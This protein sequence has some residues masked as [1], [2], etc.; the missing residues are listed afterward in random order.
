MHKIEIGTYAVEIPAHWNE[1]TRE[2]IQLVIELSNRKLPLKLFNAVMLQHFLKIKRNQFVKL[3]PEAV[4]AMVNCISFLHMPSQ[5]T[6]N[7]FPKLYGLHGAHDGLLNFTFEQFFEHTENAF[8][9]Y[10]ETGNKY[11]LKYLFACL[12]TPNKQFEA[13]KV[14][15]TIRR[16]FWISDNNLAA[17]LIFYTGCRNFL[18]HKFPEV[19]KKA[20][21][22]EKPKPTDGLEFIRLI[23]M[24][25]DN[26]MTKN[27]QTRITP[28]Y[29]ALEALNRI[30]TPKP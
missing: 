30:M 12:Y 4:A 13:D 21:Q 20:K 22:N 29:E 17:T 16:L 27:S 28:L 26:D 2:D 19:F 15:Q 6:V 9:K 5:L 23:T 18:I 10:L 7:K 3:N 14:E 25:N 24:L 1:L 8:F 11:F